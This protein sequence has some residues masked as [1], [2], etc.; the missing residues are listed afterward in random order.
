MFIVYFPF[1][2]PFSIFPLYL[3]GLARLNKKDPVILASPAIITFL[4][5]IQVYFI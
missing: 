3:F 4:L 5:Q 2:K 1:F